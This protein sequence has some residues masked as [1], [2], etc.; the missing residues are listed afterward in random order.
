MEA[1]DPPVAYTK[2]PLSATAMFCSNGPDRSPSR[3]ATAAPLS[4]NL[5]G[6]NGTAS[7]L[8]SARDH[9]KVA[10]G[11]VAGVEA[12][13]ERAG[14][15]VRQRHA[16]DV[17]LGG[18]LAGAPDAEDQSLPAGEHVGELGTDLAPLDGELVDR[19][20]RPSAGA[21]PRDAGVHLDVDVAVVA[22][23][24]GGGVDAVGERERRATVERQDPHRSPAADE[25]RCRPS[26]EKKGL[27]AP[28]VPGIGDG[29]QLVELPEPEARAPLAR[30]DIHQPP[31]IGRDR[32]VPCLG[33]GWSPSPGR[34]KRLNRLIGGAGAGPD[35]PHSAAAVA[36][37]ATAR[38]ASVTPFHRLA[39]ERSCDGG[40][41]VSAPSPPRAST[42]RAPGRT[43]PPCRTGRPAASP[44]R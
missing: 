31:A 8:P 43:P 22:P 1:D 38:A 18:R 20:E 15:A 41:A 40:W 33:V 5:S 4:A 16:E 11:G 7:S 24:A 3:M 39:R 28:S 36:T 12:P 30:T 6:S 21:D 27:T 29:A 42:R 23:V 14:F 35:Q 32:D 9:Q 25:P 44:A 26:G 17:E 13:D 2:V 37:T 34:K 10:G 19:L